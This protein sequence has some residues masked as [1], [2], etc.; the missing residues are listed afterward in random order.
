MSADPGLRL[1]TLAPIG[2][3][4]AVAAM[5]Q[6]VEAQGWDGLLFPDNQNLWGDTFVSMT[7]AAVATD[8]LLLGNCATNPGT[9]HPAVMASAIASIGLVSHGRAMVGIAR[10]DSALAHI[11]AS[12]VSVEIFSE[13]VRILRRLLQRQGVPFEE[14]EHWRP[15]RPIAEL[16]MDVAAPDSRLEF[17]TEDDPPV[18]VSVFVS[19][20]RTIEVA[21]QYADRVFFGLGADVDRLRWGIQSAREACERIGRDPGELQFA[22]GLSV[23]I[24]DDIAH[25]RDQVVHMVASS[26]RFSSMHGRVAGPTS[27]ANRAVYEQVAARYDMTHHGQMGSQVDALTPDFIDAFAVVGSLDRCVERLREIHERGIS[28]VLIG[29]ARSDLVSPD[30]KNP[31]VTVVEELLPALRA[32]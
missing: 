27:E 15:S 11:G 10:G 6:R 8:R 19:G 32:G 17:L 4:H 25:A 7:Q 31:A 23:G 2:R 29:P 22:A 12:P 21:A 5:A 9:R 28:D 24:S 16:P 3:P 1:W 13:Y 20:P 26:A 14:L 30:G 18:P